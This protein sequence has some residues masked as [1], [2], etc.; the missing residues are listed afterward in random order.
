MSFFK[1][2]NRNSEITIKEQELLYDT[3]T[4]TYGEESDYE[5]SDDEKSC[6]DIDNFVKEVI[7]EIIED[8]DNPGRTELLK[9]IKELEERILYLEVKLKHI[10][11]Y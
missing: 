2:F 9:K 4:D 11:Y 7:D 3:G 8:E 5:S 6:E 10:L 1:I